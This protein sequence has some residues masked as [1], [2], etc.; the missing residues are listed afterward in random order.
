LPPLVGGLQ[1]RP[2]D[3]RSIRVP[4]DRT[5]STHPERGRRAAMGRR[6][7]LHPSGPRQQPL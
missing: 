5:G 1:D 2:A 4:P 6:T 3:A 7:D